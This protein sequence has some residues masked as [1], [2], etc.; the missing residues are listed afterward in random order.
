MKC[1]HFISI[2]RPVKLL[3]TFFG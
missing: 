2:R 3:Q 1:L